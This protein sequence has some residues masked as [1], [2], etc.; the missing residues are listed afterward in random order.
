MKA[1]IVTAATHGEISLLLAELEGGR[2]LSVGRREVHGG[3]LR[4]TSVLLALTG[5]GKIN[6]ASAVTALLEHFDPALL[7]N[8]GC[9]G[10]YPECGL[11]VGDL[12]LATAELLGDE[13]VEAPDGWHSLE[14]IGIPAVARDGAEYYNRFP[15]TGWA[16]EKA[17]HV[18]QGAGIVLCRGDFVTVSTVSGTAGRGTELFRRFGGICENMEGGAIAQ[19]ASLYGINCL[20]VRGVSNLVEDRDFSRWNI[21]LASERAQQFV[22]QFISSL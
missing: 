13:G 3:I 20:E 17:A 18:A 11:A 5:I 12:A 15:L 2:R 21:P 7:I 4:G 1:V 10:A 14:F 6:A 19:V 16:T 9:A 22:L 8:I